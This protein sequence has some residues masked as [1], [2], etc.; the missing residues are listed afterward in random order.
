MTVTATSYAPI[1]YNG[2]GSTS[3]FNITFQFYEIAVIHIDSSGSETEWTENTHYTVTGGE[4]S[5]GSVTITTT[6]PATGE[7]LRIERRTSKD[8]SRDYDLD[9]QVLE[10]A[11]QTS[12]DKLAMVLQELDY[13]NR[14]RP[15]ISKTN[16]T[17]EVEFPTASTGN[18]LSWG[19]D[20]NLANTALLDL[21]GI[22]ISG[23]STTASLEDADLVPLYD[24]SAGDNAAITWANVKNEVLTGLG[25]LASLNSIGGTNINADTIT[26]AKLNPYA[27][28]VPNDDWN[29]ISRTGYWA[30]E[31]TVNNPKGSDTRWWI[32]QTIVHNALYITQEVWDFT[33]DPQNVR[34]FRR[35]KKNGTWYAWEPV[36]GCSGEF[37]IQDQ[38]SSGTH[39]GAATGGSTNIRTLNT[40]VKNT[41]SGA[42]L[43]GNNI[44][45]PAGTYV[46]EAEAT[47][48][49]VNNHKLKIYNL[50]DGA[51][52]AEGLSMRAQD[53]DVGSSRG[54]VQ[55]EFTLTA[56]KNLLLRHYTQD[57][58]A[59]YG[60]GFANSIGIEI[61]ADVLIKKVA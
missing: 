40:V 35:Y 42:A 34:R 46:I 58:R 20:G 33:L 23:L 56:P 49:Q 30:G 15:A 48:C 17:T 3:V 26:N 14:R 61:Y 54:F 19:S 5:T 16:F 44:Y 11:L 27:E 31:Y 13:D 28:P 52:L 25:T 18:V 39:G 41:I 38:R 51:Y 53:A 1:T 21:D 10:D 7:Q 50:T 8:Q 60:L 4:G 55:G 9:N 22:A 47:V 59:S 36:I 43:N 24:Q 2:N 37:H 12:D 57:T 6:A 29:D 32:G 45:L